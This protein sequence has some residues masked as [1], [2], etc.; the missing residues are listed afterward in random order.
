MPPAR[1]SD[2]GETVT[3]R[4]VREVE[5]SHALMSGTCKTE[6]PRDMHE[7]P[8]LPQGDRPWLHTARE[9]RRRRAAY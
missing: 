4:K 9:H 1:V 2:I 7:L 3:A 5:A 6:A 8:E